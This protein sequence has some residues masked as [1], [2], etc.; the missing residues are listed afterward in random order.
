MVA[1]LNHHG[2]RHAPAA[3]GRPR[4]S[5]S[6][7]SSRNFRDGITRTNSIALVGSML[8]ADGRRRPLRPTY[9]ELLVGTADGPASVTLL[10]DA[11]RAG[12]LCHSRRRA[13]SR[14]RSPC[15]P[16]RSTP[17]RSRASTHPRDWPKRTARLV[18]RAAGRF[19]RLG[20]PALRRTHAVDHEA[21]DLRRPG[22]RS[23]TN[24]IV[25]DH[26]RRTG[27][28]RT[29]GRPAGRRSRGR[30]TRRDRIVESVAGRPSEIGAL[31][32]SGRQRRSRRRGRRR[33]VRATVAPCD[34]RCGGLRD[35]PTARSS[36]C[37][38]RPNTQA[39][40]ASGRGDPSTSRATRRHRRAAGV[41]W[42]TYR[43][44]ADRSTL[45]ERRQT[46]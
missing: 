24:V 8:T 1:A 37:G 18:W 17:T 44:A 23:S 15:A 27:R 9:R 33:S 45:C 39:A 21:G 16:V 22:R 25:A 40:S 19:G 3:V 10:T 32:G 43:A 11:R 36:A 13:T 29:S 30:R 42:P 2:R 31:V 14:S 20:Q 46:R 6:N 28:S 34:G 38:H 5:T 26:R 4:S 7:P 41:S 35:R 12:H